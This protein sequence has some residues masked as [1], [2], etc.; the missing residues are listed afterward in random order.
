M[1][2]RVISKSRLST[3][4]HYSM[5][6]WTIVCFIGTWVVIL[7]YGILKKGLIGLMLTFFIAAAFWVIPLVG[8][9]VLSLSV[10]P[11]E[12]PLQFVKF[13]DLIRK[14]M[15]GSSAEMK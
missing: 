11:A 2:T 12:E 8:L 6:I 7:T 5:L 4:I 14:G 9:I 15:R 10:T 13:K 1:E 3:I